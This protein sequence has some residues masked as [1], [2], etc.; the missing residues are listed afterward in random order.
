MILV[1]QSNRPVLLSILS[2]MAFAQPTE[3]TLILDEFLFKLYEA[4]KNACIAG[5]SATLSP[6]M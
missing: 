4:Y 2:G 1:A 5:D 6:D 3:I